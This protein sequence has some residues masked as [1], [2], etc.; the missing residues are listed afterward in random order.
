MPR[1]KAKGKW[2][3][4]MSP[5]EW[6]WNE[7]PHG[8]QI[9][10]EEWN[11]CDLIN[12]I[13]ESGQ[14]IIDIGC[15]EGHFTKHYISSGFSHSHGVG[16]DVSNIAIGRARRLYKTNKLDFVVLDITKEEYWMDGADTIIMSEVLYYIKPELWKTVANNI[17]KMLDKKEQFIISVGQYFTEDDIR[18]IFS[19]INF[20]KV[21]KLPSAKYEYNLIMSGHYER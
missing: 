9:N 17:Y 3:L 1:E 10:E 18:K 4:K 20:D 15:G 14:F 21:F 7:D 6:Y 8:I 11:K 16:L 2:N 5:D 19:K 12:G 13:I